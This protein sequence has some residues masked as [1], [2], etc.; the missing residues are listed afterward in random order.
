MQKVLGSISFGA[1]M[2]G[3]KECVDASNLAN[4]ILDHALKPAGPELKRECTPHYLDELLFFKLFAVDYVL[5]LKAVSDPV[6][7]T[8]RQQYN[9]GL[10]EFCANEESPFAYDTITTRFVTYSE[11][12]NA[13]TTAPKEYKGKRIVFWELGK[14]F[15]RLASDA[16]P[17]VPSAVEVSLH[18]NIFLSELKRLSDFLEHYEV[19]SV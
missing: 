7:A 14:A 16:D 11:A 4:A 12:C 18:V 10:E 19:T 3:E 5:G 6:F 2:A 1:A 17:W 15:S 13:N 9:E 8:V